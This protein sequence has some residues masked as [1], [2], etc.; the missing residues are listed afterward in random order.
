[1][2]TMQKRLALALPTVLM[3]ALLAP[4]FSRISI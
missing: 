2:K 1:M 4:V 3:M